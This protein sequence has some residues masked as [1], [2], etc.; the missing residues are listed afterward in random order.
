MLCCAGLFIGFFIGQSLGGPWTA[1]APMAGFLLG[2]YADIKT[3]RKGAHP[4]HH[5]STGINCKGT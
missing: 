2:L 1:V 4:A 5:D 3:C